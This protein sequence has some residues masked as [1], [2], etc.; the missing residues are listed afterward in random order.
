MELCA[1]MN[2]ETENLDLI[3]SLEPGEIFYDLGACEGRFSIYAALR[4]L[5]VFSFEPNS[6]NHKVFEQNVELNN[7]KGTISIFNVGVGDSNKSGILQIGQP[8]PGGHQK[9]IKHDNVRSDLNFEFIANETIEIVSLDSFIETN[10]LPIP[11]TLKIDI[12]GSEV[13]F[14]KGAHKTLNNKSVKKILIE[15]DKTDK[16]Y[17][18]IVSSLAVFGY[19]YVDEFP[20]P[21]EQSLYNFL[22]CR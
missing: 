1:L 4:K 9:V 17:D 8:W 5:K 20:I 10:I 2:Y 18:Y 12:D 14:L 6:Q 3:D 13:P 7:L 16:N 15:L 21:N 11:N 19:S 22:F